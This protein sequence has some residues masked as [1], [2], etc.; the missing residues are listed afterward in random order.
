[1]TL[2]HDKVRAAR[3]LMILRAAVARLEKSQPGPA[4]VSTPEDIESV[5][6]AVD[7]VLHFVVQP[8][9]YRVIRR[10]GHQR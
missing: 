6:D 10:Q 5:A 7:D 3:A 2:E 9:D 1:M 4:A 8:Q